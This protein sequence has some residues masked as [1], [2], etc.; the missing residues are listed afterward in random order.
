[1]YT[2]PPRHLGGRQCYGKDVATDG[3]AVADITVEDVLDVGGEHCRG[4]RRRLCDE[5]ETSAWC[6]VLRYVGA[7][8]AENFFAEGGDVFTTCCCG[9]LRRCVRSSSAVDGA[10]G[11]GEL[12]GV[13]GELLTYLG[14]E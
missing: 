1:M 2:L 3:T 6:A 9:R 14:G 7:V 12:Q 13:V 4:G 10:R 8:A 11:L 5:W